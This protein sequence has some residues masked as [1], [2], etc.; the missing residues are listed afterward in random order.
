MRKI[1]VYIIA[2]LLGAFLINPSSF[3]NDLER[4]THHIGVIVPLTGSL[5]LVGETIKNIIILA[6]QDLDPKQSLKLTFDDSAFDPARAATIAQRMINAEKVDGLIVFGSGVSMALAPIAER[7]K[8]PMLSM[9]ISPSNKGRKYVFR[10]FPDT[11]DLSGAV[12]KEVIKRNYKNLA[13]VTNIQ[14]GLITLREIFKK[15]ISLPFLADVEVMMSETDVRT[16]ALKVKNSGADAVYLLLLP[17][18]L[19]QFAK[20]LRQI[21]YKGDLFSNLQAQYTSEVIAASGA[22][23]SMWIATYDDSKSAAIKER[24]LSNM[25]TDPN[26][27]GMFGYDAFH[28]FLEASKAANLRD[29]LASID[30]FSGILGTY[31]VTSDNN[32]YAP[33]MTKKVVGEK[34]VSLN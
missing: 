19:S 20:A 30:K 7:A 25:K 14:D 4:D 13:L 11:E 6:Q 3:A 5:A 18:H 16:A 27:D 33:V 10:I 24:L 2:L 17:P 28:L 32:F 31:R 9:A 22:L 15:L 29:G 34:F 12:V 8:I 1:T 23:E 26:P 21:G